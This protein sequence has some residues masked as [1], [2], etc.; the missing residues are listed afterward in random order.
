[1]ALYNRGKGGRSHPGALGYSRSDEEINAMVQAEGTPSAARSAACPITGA[2]DIHEAC[3]DTMLGRWVRS[4]SKYDNWEA[5]ME[6]F[7][8]DEKMVRDET[9]EP[10]IHVFT[11]F[12]KQS[13]TILH[14]LPERDGL[15]V[16]Y[17][18]PIDGNQYP[19]PPI[20]VKNARSSW[21]ANATWAH[22]WD[23]RGLR[24]FQVPPEP[25]LHRSLAT[26]GAQDAQGRFQPAV[27]AVHG[28]R[29]RDQDLS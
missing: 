7:G 1:M 22:S 18:I 14:I 12:S 17:T 11:A 29:D 27:L 2:I 21:K 20:M 3:E 16:E 15:Q 19:I 10:Q 13:M 25:F 8:M 5:Y 6:W 23:E 28:L 26:A 24:T 9:I 4:P